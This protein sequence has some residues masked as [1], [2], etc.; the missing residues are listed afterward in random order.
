MSHRLWILAAIFLSSAG[1]VAYTT[2]PEVVPM[3]QAFSSMPTIVGAW[4][5][6]ANQ[7][8]AAS[9]LDVLGVTDYVNRTY[10]RGP[11]E[12]ASL[13]IGYYDSQREGDTMHSPMNCLP[14]AGWIPVETKMVQISVAGRSAPIVVK[15]VIIEKGIDRQLVL[16]WY[17]SHGRVIGNEYW[18]KVTMVYDALRLNRSDAALVRVVTPILAGAAAPAPDDL[19]TDFVQSIFPQLDTYLPS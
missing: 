18:S 9:I 6:S 12:V 5:G 13:Y 1:F 10:Y 8:L 15:R 3:R 17:Q 7:P 14:G 16:Y 19:A 2:R 11:R 4:R